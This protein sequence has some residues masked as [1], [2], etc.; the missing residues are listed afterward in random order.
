[1]EKLG[2]NLFELLNSDLKTTKHF[3]L[4]NAYAKFV[5]DIKHLNQPGNDCIDILR[6][7]NFTHIE[8]MSLRTFPQNE[9]GKKCT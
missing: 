9:Q 5:E 7:L 4:T 6:L 2:L 8:L 1:M 3:E